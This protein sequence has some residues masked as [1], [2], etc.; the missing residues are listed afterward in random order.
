M[1]DEKISD[2]NQVRAS[3]SFDEETGADRRSVMEI[4]GLGKIDKKH[5][6]RAQKQL[7]DNHNQNEI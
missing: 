1:A 4:Y 7:N 2:W 6:I 3:K 5:L